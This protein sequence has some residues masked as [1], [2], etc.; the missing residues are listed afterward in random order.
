MSSAYQFPRIKIK[1]EWNNHIQLAKTN[2]EVDEAVVACGYYEYRML[3]SGSSSFE[4]QLARREYLAELLDIIHCVETVLHMEDVDDEE[5][6]DIKRF[7]I[8]KNRKRGYYD[9]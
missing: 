5:Y 3:I 9:D 4:T 2:E 7:V 6:E 1:D 8:E